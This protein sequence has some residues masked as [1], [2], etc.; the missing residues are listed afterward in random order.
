MLVAAALLAGL[1][2]CADR[3]IPVQSPPTGAP[4]QEATEGA[5]VEI[6]GAITALS[7]GSEEEFLLRVVGKGYLPITIDAGLGAPVR[8]AGVIVAVPDGFDTA[9][10]DDELFDALLEV[11]QESGE[12]LI[13]V[14]YLDVATG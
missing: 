8:Q 14:G 4:S 2:A 7:S 12:S 13:V 10:T 3:G 6:A 5:S 1:S 9:L 11:T